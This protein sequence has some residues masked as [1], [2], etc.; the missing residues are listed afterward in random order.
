MATRA[1]LATEISTRLGDAANA[2]WP[3]A[4][5]KSYVDYAIK[6][7]YPSFYLRKVGTTAVASG[8]VQT[9]PAGVK[10]LYLIGYNRQD[11]ARVRNIRGWAE[12]AGTAFIPKQLEVGDTLVW[13]WTVGWDAP[14]SDGEVLTIPTE[15]EEVVILRS[16]IAA[17]ERLLSDRVSAEKYFA[18]QV[19]QAI[20]E[21]DIATSIDALQ[22]SLRDRLAGVVPLPEAIR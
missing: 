8:L 18:L 15:A 5:V 17:L 21:E 3:L 1:L 9:G 19:R 7:L 16:Q 10:N 12:G 20:T 2:I 14:A 11:T 6:G 22:A 4:E 13:A